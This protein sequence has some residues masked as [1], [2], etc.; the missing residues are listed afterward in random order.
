MPP[1]TPSSGALP[2]KA[3]ALETL[4]TG[5]H[6]LTESL[7]LC[8]LKNIFGGILMASGGLLS[9]TAAMGMPR[10]TEGNPGLKMLVQGVTFPVGFVM[11]YLV[12]S[13]L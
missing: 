12:E 5:I 10:V 4:D 11:V 6:H 13:E 2:P 1:Q 7:H 3:A 9:F 8:F